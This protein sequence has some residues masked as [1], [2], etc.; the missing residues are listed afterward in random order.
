MN[1]ALSNCGPRNILWELADP[2]ELDLAKKELDRVNTE[3][4]QLNAQVSAMSQELNRKTDKIRKHHAEQAV[5]FQRIQELI[6]QPA[7]AINKARMYD[8]LIKSADLFQARKT[9]PILV[10]YTRLMNGL[11]EDIQKLIPPGRTPRQLLYQG[12][13]GSPTGTLYEAVGEVE[14]VRNP[15][16]AVEPREGSRPGSTG[17]EPEMTRSSQARQKNTGS[18]RFGQGHSPARRSLDRSCT[19]ERSRT[20]VR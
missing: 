8:E 12:P 3:N 9:I 17:W 2:K 5:V 7:E 13:L 6:G 16:M 20:P 15:P 19:P 14:V 4:A 10:K 1:Q 11:F 18:E